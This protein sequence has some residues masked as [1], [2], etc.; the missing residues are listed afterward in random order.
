MWSG[1][2]QTTKGTGEDFPVRQGGVRKLHP[3]F[4]IVKKSFF[5]YG[6]VVNYARVAQLVEHSTDTRGVPGSNPGTRTKKFYNK[7]FACKK[8]CYDFCQDLKTFDSF[9]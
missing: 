8:S 1:W 4:S 2:G 7:I 3:P 5:W 9:L 6:I